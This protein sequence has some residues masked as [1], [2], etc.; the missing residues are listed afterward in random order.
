LRS[1]LFD[2]FVQRQLIVREALKKNIVPTEDEI[3][4]AVEDQHQQTNSA[5]GTKGGVAEQSQPTLD[6]GERREELLNELLTLKYYK[7]EVLRD[8]QVTEQEIADYY[9]KNHAHYQQ[10]NGFYVREIRVTSADEAQKLHQQAL[11]KPGDFAVLA[12]EHSQAPTAIQGGLMFYE[13]QQLPTVLAQAI[14]PLKVN[15]ISKVVQSNYGFH[16]FKLERRA[17]PRALAEVQSEIKDKLLSD[18][19]QTLINAFNERAMAAAKIKIYY[20][21]LGFNYSGALKAGA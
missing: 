7:S 1:R 3:R 9:N 19:N 17:Q 6:G 8:V 15:E 11:S 18:K 5:S 14:T 4:K 13:A 12:K 10:Q 20:D 2:E 21:R 16:I